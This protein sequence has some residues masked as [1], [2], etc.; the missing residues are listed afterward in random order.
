MSGRR[1]LNAPRTRARKFQ[2][3]QRDGQRCAY[4]LTPFTTLREATLDHVAPLSLL[5]SW[6]ARHLVLACRP[7]NNRKADRLPLLLALLLLGSTDASHPTGPGQRSVEEEEEADFHPAV[8]GKSPMFTAVFTVFTDPTATPD[9]EATTLSTDG[10][11]AVDAA[12]FHRP[13][14]VLLARLAHARHMALTSVTSRVTPRPVDREQSGEHHGEHRERSGGHQ[15]VHSAER[16][17]RPVRARLC[18][19]HPI[20]SYTAPQEAA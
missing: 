15:P 4:C 10:G 20:T 18:A 5:R 19:P 8:H 1:V 16:V 11:N 12:A 3:A 14:W 13:T 2:L 6:S 9:R 17:G 7:C